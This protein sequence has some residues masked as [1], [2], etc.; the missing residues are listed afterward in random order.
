MRLSSINFNVRTNKYSTLGIES[1]QIKESYSNVFEQL[2]GS[3]TTVVDNDIATRFA[4]ALNTFDMSEAQKITL[5]KIE[6]ELVKI[7]NAIDPEK[8]YFT[9][10]QT[11]DGE[12][13]IN[14]K[15]QTHFAKVIV[16]DDGLV[17]YSEIAYFNNDDQLIFFEEDVDLEGLLYSFLS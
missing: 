5:R 12:I 7:Q 6:A 8:L 3:L 16:Q 4:V 17:A 1:D 9:I 14:N 15:T 2:K 13:C 10:T 11:F